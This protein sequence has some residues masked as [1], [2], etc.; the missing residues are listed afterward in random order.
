MNVS[1]IKKTV[2]ENEISKE[3]YVSRF[4]EIDLDRLS[5]LLRRIVQIDLMLMLF[6]GFSRN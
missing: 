4:P 5:G 1:N 6:T 3:L 2:L